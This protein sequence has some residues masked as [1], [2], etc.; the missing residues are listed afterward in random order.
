VRD[1]PR[2]CGQLSLDVSVRLRSE[3]ETTGGL[4]LCALSRILAPWLLT[5]K[6]PWLSALPQPQ[7]KTLMSKHPCHRPL[8][9]HIDRFPVPTNED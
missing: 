7:A 8:L 2:H 9:F 5:S 3:T 4:S 1:G 6:A